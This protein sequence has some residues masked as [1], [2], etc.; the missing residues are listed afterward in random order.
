VSILQQLQSLPAAKSVGGTGTFYEA[1]WPNNEDRILKDKTIREALFYAIDREEILTGLIHLNAPE[2]EVLNCGPFSLPGRGP[3]CAETPWDIFTY[4]PEK[5]VELLEGAGWDCSGVPDNPCSK[6]GEDLTLNYRY[7]NGN[8]RRG[9]TFDLIKEK[10]KPAGFAFS[11]SAK[12]NTCAAPLF[13]QTLPSGNFQ[14][15]DYAQ[16]PIAVDPSPTSNFRCDAIPTEANKFAGA[17]FTRYCDPETD[18]L[19]KEAD[20]TV[21][22]DARLELL[23]QVWQRMADARAFLPIYV[24]P[25]V[26]IWRDDKLGGPVGGSNSSPY[27]GLFNADEWY[28]K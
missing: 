26:T 4:Q 8:A 14:V 25:N 18:T 12:G 27:G 19:M 9:T 3:W 6:G 23:N 11:H 17:N 13:T 20:A 7:C 10:V 5:S 1:L 21:D 28:L 15:G 24:L 2:E 22:P 16:G